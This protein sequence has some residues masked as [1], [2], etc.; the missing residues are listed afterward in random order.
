MTTE[1]SAKQRP[2]QFLQLRIDNL[3]GTLTFF[4]RREEHKVAFLL[5]IDFWDWE[6][7]EMI[8]AVGNFSEREKAWRVSG[9]TA[10]EILRSQGLILKK[11][12]RI[13]YGPAVQTSEIAAP[14]ADLAKLIAAWNDLISACNELLDS[15]QTEQ[16]LKVGGKALRNLSKY[17][18]AIPS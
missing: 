11:R 2:S 4:S 7:D 13:D 15:N 12:V 14:S 3:A 8:Y 1:V 9:R 6:M 18:K 16:T 17:R 10:D 5:Q